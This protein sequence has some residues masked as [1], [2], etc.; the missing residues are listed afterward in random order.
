MKKLMLASLLAAF[1]LSSCE[2]DTPHGE[3]VGVLE[4]KDPKLEYEPSLRNIIIA[5]FFSPGGLIVPA[6]VILDGH[7]C[8]VGPKATP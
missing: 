2:C 6:I 3:C 7:S 1:M 4:H 8:P 5:A